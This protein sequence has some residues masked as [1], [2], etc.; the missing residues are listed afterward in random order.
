MRRIKG[1][2]SHWINQNVEPEKK[3]AWQEGYGIFSVSEENIKKVRAY[4]YNQEE[5][6]RSMSYVEEIKKLR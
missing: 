2:S 6:H 1:E 5:H 4:I 3:F